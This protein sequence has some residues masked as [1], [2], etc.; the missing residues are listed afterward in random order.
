[1][2]HKAEVRELHHLSY[3]GKEDINLSR[4]IIRKVRVLEGF[5]AEREVR[6]RRLTCGTT[7]RVVGTLRM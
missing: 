5:W 7:G 2:I 4:K 6:G 3:E 1:M